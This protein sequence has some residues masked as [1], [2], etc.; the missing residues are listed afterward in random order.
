MDSL[1]EKSPSGFVDGICDCLYL[2]MVTY[3]LMI[4]L[5]LMILLEEGIITM[6][7]AVAYFAILEIPMYPEILLYTLLDCTEP[8]WWWW[9]DPFFAE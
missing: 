2:L 9:D 7:Q 6:E 3:G 4:M 1:D 8:D 5:P